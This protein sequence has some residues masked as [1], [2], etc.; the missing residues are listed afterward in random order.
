MK[1]FLLLIVY[2]AIGAV[3]FV[4]LLYLGSSHT[5]A[6]DIHLTFGLTLIALLLVIALPKNE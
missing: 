5:I 3:L 4:W 6:S 1:T 2:I